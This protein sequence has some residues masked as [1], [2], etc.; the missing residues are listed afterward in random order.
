MF[1][2]INRIEF[3]DRASDGVSDTFSSGIWASCIVL[4]GKHGDIWGFDIGKL[5]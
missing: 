4:S 1:L 3:F 2:V 5:K